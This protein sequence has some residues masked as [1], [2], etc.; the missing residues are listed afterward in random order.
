MDGIV[1]P[2]GGTRSSGAGWG[3]LGVR[4]SCA[5]AGIGR[6]PSFTVSM[7]EDAEVSIGANP[8]CTLPSSARRRPEGPGANRV[9]P[10]HPQ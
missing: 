4:C 9:V 3:T 7:A 10:A 5:V 2:A 6:V 1:V 8:A